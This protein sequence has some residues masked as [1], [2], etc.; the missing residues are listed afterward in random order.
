MYTRKR[1]YDRLRKLNKSQGGDNLLFTF[2][3]E[4]MTLENTGSMV[5]HFQNM[6]DSIIEDGTAI[7][8]SDRQMKIRKK[9]GL[10]EFQF[11]NEEI[12]KIVK[13]SSEGKDQ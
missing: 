2:Y 6:V 9:L 7:P 8:V 10:P 3:S 11:D 4:V 1:I 13:K 5:Q 12:K